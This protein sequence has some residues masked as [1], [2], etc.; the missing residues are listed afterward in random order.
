MSEITICNMALAHLGQAPINSY[1]DENERAR[2]C[3][4]FYPIALQ[5]LLKAHPWRFADVTAPLARVPWSWRGLEW[6]H[7]YMRPA[8]ALRVHGVYGTESLQVKYREVSIKQGRILLTRAPARWVNYTRK[9]TNTDLFDADFSLALSWELAVL[10]AP[11]LS[12]D[13]SDINRCRQMAAET[14]DTARCNNRAEGENVLHLRSTYV[15][16]L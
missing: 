9:I 16:H 7:A 5:T 4:L 1:D 10:L 12:K 11:S 8:D 13:D 14:L 6:G 3:K 2:R 15:E